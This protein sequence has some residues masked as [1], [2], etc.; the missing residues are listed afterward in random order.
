M[1]YNGN[2]GFAENFVNSMILGAYQKRNKYC[3]I[4][5]FYKRLC[6]EK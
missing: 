6:N 1:K 5:K 4:L 2:S 3:S